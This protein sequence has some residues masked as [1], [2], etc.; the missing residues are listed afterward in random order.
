M[1]ICL[2]QLKID[3]KNEI[4]AKN[5]NFYIEILKKGHWVWTV[6]E[7]GVIGVRFAKKKEVM[8]QADDIG[9]HIRVPIPPGL[10]PY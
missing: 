9:R 1:K 6:V 10:L 3:Q 2:F 4:R 7:N 5:L 8:I